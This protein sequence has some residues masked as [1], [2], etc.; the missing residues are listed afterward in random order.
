MLTNLEYSSWQ[1][2]SV[3]GWRKPAAGAYLEFFP[4]RP[5]TAINIIG[6]EEGHILKI[7]FSSKKWR[8]RDKRILDLKP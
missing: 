7:D 5:W 6:S 4:I 8:M 3:A 1:D 2:A